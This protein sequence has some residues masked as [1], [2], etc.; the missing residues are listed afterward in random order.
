MRPLENFEGKFL[1]GSTRVLVAVC[2]ILSI[3]WAIS[4]LLVYRAEGTLA[5]AANDVL[6]GEKFSQEQLSQLRHTLDAT[7]FS[8][9]RPSVLRDVAIIRLRLVEESTAPSTA[10]IDDFEKALTA[11]VAGNPNS[12]LLWLMEYRLEGLRN[13][14]SDRAL[15]FLGMSYLSGPNEGWIAVRREPIALH[16][17][18]RLPPELAQLVVAEFSRL[19]QSGFYMVAANIVAGPGWAIHERLLGELAPVWEPV[20]RAFAKVLDSKDLDGATVPGIDTRQLTRCDHWS[21]HGRD[22]SP[23]APDASSTC[24]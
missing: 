23:A 19:V 14:D 12:S 22:M 7:P 21:N 18:A 24:P 16:D 4:S 8:S 5:T 11:A 9:I 2:G 10:D 1:R 15:K 17:F 20:R 6:Q 3:G 13:G